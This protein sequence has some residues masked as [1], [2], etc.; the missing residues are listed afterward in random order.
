MSRYQFLYTGY[1]NCQI[2]IYTLSGNQEK[3]FNKLSK[4]LQKFASDFG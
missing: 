1:I 3:K 4:M 2:L